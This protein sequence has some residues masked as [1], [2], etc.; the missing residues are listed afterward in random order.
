MAPTL[1]ANYC[2]I[3]KPS[4]IHLVAFFCTYIKT[5]SNCFPKG[6]LKHYH[7][8]PLAFYDDNEN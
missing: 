3:C 8:T 7:M 1:N 6:S 4:A 5:N 2:V